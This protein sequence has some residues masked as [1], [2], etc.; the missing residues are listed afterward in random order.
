MIISP[1]AR[2]TAEYFDVA[3]VGGG[4]AGAVTALCLARRGIR[5]ALLEATRLEGD[6][7]GETLP[8]EINPVLRELGL[9]DAFSALN[10][11]PAPG[12]VSAWGSAI[13]LEQDFISNAHG[14]G[15]HI[16]R[17]R[18]DAMLCQEG[19]AAGVSIFLACQVRPERISDGV[20]NMNWRLGDINAA[21]V[22]DAA[23]RTGLRLD[24]AY[25]YEK[26][27]ALLAI[28]LRLS[29]ADTT[30][31]RT[32]IETTPQG[33]WYTAPLPNGQMIAMFFTDPEIYSNEGIVPGDQLE[34]APLTAHR[35]RSSRIL[36]SR[37]VHAPSA[38]RAKMS[39]DGWLAVGD[40]ASSYDPLSGRGI[41]KACRHGAAAAVAISTGAMDDYDTRV[42]REFDEYVRQRR[43]HYAS[44][45]RW[46]ESI[47][48]QKR[49][50]PA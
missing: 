18:F 41:F 39:G 4:P 23:G 40:S 33:W 14:C 44:E 2:K 7:Y 8:P 10:S 38:C 36:T 29:G 32:V 20:V 43:T 13:P 48:W 45:R 30:D 26:D 22:V 15:W 11:V 24:D 19:A 37:V 47:F 6:R 9:W 28:V 25:D 16:D 50:Y 49:T 42:R 46:P 12:I 5:V 31:L 27:D 3:I 21:F 17:N 1:L 35:L 34:H